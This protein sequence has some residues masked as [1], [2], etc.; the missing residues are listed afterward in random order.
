EERAPGKE[1]VEAAFERE[2]TA[3]DRIAAS[4]NPHDYYEFLK[5][6]P[7]GNISEQ[8][9]AVLERLA[10]AKTKPVADRDGMVQVPAR[11]RFQEGD[12][13][14]FVERNQYSNNVIRTVRNRVRKV[15]ED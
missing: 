12:I 3:W 5:G 11:D 2:K 14:A 15:T 13:N 7:S 1:A 8:A 4:R 9:Q 6:W 10:S